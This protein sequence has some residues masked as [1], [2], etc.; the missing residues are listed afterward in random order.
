MT[1][2][3]SCSANGQGTHEIDFIPYTVL[4]KFWFLS[5]SRAVHRLELKAGCTGYLM[6]FNSGFYHPKDKSASEWLRKASRKN[7][8]GPEMHGFEKLFNILSS[9]SREYTDREEGFMDIIKANPEI[10]FIEFVR[11]GPNPNSLSINI[12]AYMQERF[13]RIFRVCGKTYYHL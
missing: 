12:S 8:C 11:Q 10:F 1:F 4:N 2:F 5:A 7:Y 9:I 13:R 3:Y 6:E